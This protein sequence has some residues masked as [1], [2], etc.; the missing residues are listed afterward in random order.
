[1]KR[2]I[3]ILGL[4]VLAGC[5][6][7]GGGQTDPLLS[8]IIPKTLDDYGPTLL[9]NAQS[10]CNVGAA[11]EF[12]ANMVICADP[13]TFVASLPISMNGAEVVNA[14]K[15]ICQ[16]NGYT[17]AGLPATAT[18]GNCV[19]PTPVPTPAAK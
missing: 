6:T 1:M 11:K 13:A 3:V 17:G 2:L 8:R 4:V 7:L 19:Y 15:A 14:V 5:A 9:G 10:S 16:V 12:N 18:V